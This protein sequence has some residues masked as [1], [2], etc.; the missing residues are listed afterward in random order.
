M[1]RA[2][3]GCQ[4]S[5]HRIPGI[6]HIK[7]CCHPSDEELR[8]DLVDAAMKSLDRVVFTDDFEYTEQ[9]SADFR[10]K[11][12][13]RREER[14]AELGSLEHVDLPAWMASAP[15]RKR[16][17]DAMRREQ[18]AR[19]GIFEPSTHPLAKPWGEQEWHRMGG[20]C[21]CDTCG[22]EYQRHQVECG[23][24]YGNCGEA[25]VYLHRLCDGRLAK[26]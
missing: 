20:G 18:L 7:A 3:G 13:E 8:A 11:L 4:C 10:Q 15:A 24:A 16:L 19:D 26:L 25:I 21:I 2:Y 5:C 12:G 14:A 9:D 22:E 1:P 23:P 17:A 6:M